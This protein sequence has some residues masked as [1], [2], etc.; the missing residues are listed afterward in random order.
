M[1]VLSRLVTLP[2]AGPLT[3]SLWLARKIHETAEEE[4]NDPARIRAE[5]A[6]LEADLLSGRITEDAYDAAETTLLMRLRGL[7]G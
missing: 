4:L 1:G 3:G 2:V 7:G 5:L 6:R